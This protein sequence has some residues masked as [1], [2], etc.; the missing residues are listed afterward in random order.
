MLH[1]KI[2]ELI[3]NS[4]KNGKKDD[5]AIYR[6]IKFEFLKYEKSDEFDG[7]SEEKEM[8]ILVKMAAQHEDSIA[9][10]KA[11]GRDD[12]AKDEENELAVLRQYVPAITDNDIAEHTRGVITAYKLAKDDGYKLSM[13]DMNPIMNE[14]HKKYPTANGKIISEVLKS[15][16]NG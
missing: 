13:R 8:S 7:W 1:D 16:I 15:V 5:I 3:G 14:V 12:L 10:Y 2:D 9:Q 11:N 6:L 4:M